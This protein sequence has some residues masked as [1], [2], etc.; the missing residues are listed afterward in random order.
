MNKGTIEQTLED[1][2]MPHLIAAWRRM[3]GK[4]GKATS[5]SSRELEEVA[6]SVY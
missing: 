4:S 3:T 1:V 6:A 2:W 5:L